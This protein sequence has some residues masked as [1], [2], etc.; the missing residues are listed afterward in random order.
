MGND[1]QSMIKNH[2]IQT[3]TTSSKI[4]LRIEIKIAII[5]RRGYLSPLF[6]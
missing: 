2:L 5:V 6:K 4:S 1:Y 3:P